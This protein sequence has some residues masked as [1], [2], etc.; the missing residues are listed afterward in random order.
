[1]F[2]K[3]DYQRKRAATGFYSRGHYI[4]GEPAY[5]WHRGNFMAPEQWQIQRLPEGSRIDGA[6]TL[7]TAAELVTAGSPNQT[8]DRILFKGTEYEV[9]AG[10]RWTSHNW[11]ILTKAGQ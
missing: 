8:A 11:Y 4:K 3:H 1:M 10:E 9:S 2:Y 5:S 6:V 7:Y